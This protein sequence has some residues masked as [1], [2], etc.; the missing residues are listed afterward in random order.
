[1]SRRESEKGPLP[2][3]GLPRSASNLNTDPSSP[4][5]D[6][7]ILAFDW[8]GSH[9]LGLNTRIAGT[10]TWAYVGPHMGISYVALLC[11]KVCGCSGEN[12]L[13][14]T[15]Q[16]R[17][18]TVDGALLANIV[19]DAADEATQPSIWPQCPG[20]MGCRGSGGSEVC[21][22]T[23]TSSTPVRRH[24][25]APWVTAGLTSAKEKRR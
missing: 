19:A 23:H 4:S 12:K 13:M 5:P 11:Q 6:M 16:A 22:R 18:Q 15:P 7:G 20:G 1:M 9:S 25:S 10:S 24:Y 8:Y 3:L 2:L 17:V 21:N 14:W